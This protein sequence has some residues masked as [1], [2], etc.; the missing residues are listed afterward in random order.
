MTNQK[1]YPR[2]VSWS[3]HPAS[4]YLKGDKELLVEIY[5]DDPKGEAIL[6]QGI[7]PSLGISMRKAPY[8]TI[9]RTQGRTKRART[10]GDMKKKIENKYPE[11]K[12]K[13]KSTDRKILDFGEYIFIDLPFIN[14]YVNPIVT[15]DKWYNEQ[16]IKKTEFT[17]DFIKE[18]IK[19]RPVALFDR[20][21]ITDF[22]EKALP[23]FL[24]ELAIFDEDLYKEAV[25]GT[26]FEE[27]EISYTGIKAK[28]NTLKPGKVK[29]RLDISEEEF[30]W[31][32]KLLTRKQRTKDNSEV[33]IRPD[34]EVIVK[35][36]DNN[37]VTKNTE[38]I[39]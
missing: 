14:N 36:F 19:Y 4:P 1:T 38:F 5:L 26:A 17:V 20:K 7:L 9:K 8:F 37:T 25:K 3:Y 24:R 12:D 22:Q 16:Y 2:L 28:L 23:N 13:L 6:E 21:E 31:D 30:Y 11:L 39:S 32:G 35:I 27:K 15:E 10:H 33:I 18:L 29:Y 34:K